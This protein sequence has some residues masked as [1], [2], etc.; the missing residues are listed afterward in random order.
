VVSGR[1]TDYWVYV[2]GP[3]TGALLA[4]GI[5]VLVPF[6]TLTAKLFHDSRYRSI[7]ASTLP[8]KR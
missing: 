8:A 4:A 7:F 1:F 6:E 3:L 2:A 5:W